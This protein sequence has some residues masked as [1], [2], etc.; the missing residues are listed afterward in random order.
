MIGTGRVRLG[1]GIAR[2]RR[3]QRTPIGPWARTGA[4]AIH[5]QPVGRTGGTAAPTP[6]G[7]PSP[8]VPPPLP[9]GTYD[10]SRD[11]ASEESERGLGQL[12]RKLGTQGTRDTTDY[13]TARDA[14]DRQAQ[15]Q[16][17][18]YQRAQGLLR[19]SFQRLGTRQTEQA[20]VAGALQ[21]GALLQSA[22]KRA[23][24]EGQQSQAQTTNYQRAQDQIR[25]A[26]AKLD[27]Y[28]APPD[29][30]N[31]LGGRDFQDIAEQLA[32]AQSDNTFYT[33]SERTLAGQEAAERG[34]TAP[35][36]PGAPKPRRPKPVNP[37]AAARRRAW[38]GRR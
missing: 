19:Q 13:Y 24:N 18:D 29:A 5:A 3:P 12:E 35:T 17:D 32:N 26:R 1:S 21:S 22:A 11:I 27:L 9:L 15:Q 30:A 2:R 31:P 38:Q 8:W 4:A 33:T 6:N 20:N 25:L 37:F 7:G 34:Y 28:G 36:P 14:L 10:P 23:R 16:T